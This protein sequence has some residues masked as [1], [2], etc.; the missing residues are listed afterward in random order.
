MLT[1]GRTLMGNPDLVLVDEPTE[2]LSPIMVEAVVG[3]LRQI[4]KEGGSVLLVEHSI[5][6][7]LDLASH[8][9][10]MS[11]GEIVFQGTPQAFHMNE[12]VRRK[13]LEV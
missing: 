10:V 8:V 4:N 3:I 6:V 1:I 2:G 5:D 7:A 9:Y 13:Y 12:E 11:K